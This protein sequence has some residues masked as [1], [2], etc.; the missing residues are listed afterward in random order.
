MKNR[1]HRRSTKPSSKEEGVVLR[2][3]DR[4]MD[5]L[6]REYVHGGIS[7]EQIRRETA[8][9]QENLNKENI[10]IKTLIQLILDNHLADE[11]KKMYGVRRLEDLSYKRLLEFTKKKELSL[12]DYR[13]ITKSP[14]QMTKKELVN[15]ITYSRFCDLFLNMYN[16]INVSDAPTET[17]RKFAI[18]HN[19]DTIIQGKNRVETKKLREINVLLRIVKDNDMIQEMLEKYELSHIS[20]VSISQLEEFTVLRS[21]VSKEIFCPLIGIKEEDFYAYRERLEKI[22]IIRRAK[23][24]KDCLAMYELSSVSYLTIEQLESYIKIMNR[25]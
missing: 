1:K 17:L 23:C 12:S 6:L 20:N 16:V 3:I 24:I 15:C 18:E 21:L 19:L 5:R 8:R 13:N 7:D 11:C 4:E 22:D 25:Q 10:K 9:L 2:Q 14:T